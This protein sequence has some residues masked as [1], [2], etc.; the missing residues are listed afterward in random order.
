MPQALMLIDRYA[1][2]D[3]EKLNITNIGSLLQVIK[4]SQ[5]FEKTI[6]IFSYLYLSP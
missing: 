2:V 6:I 3:I 5:L 4:L 1:G